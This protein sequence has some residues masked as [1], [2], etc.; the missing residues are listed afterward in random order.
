VHQTLEH[1]G[2]RAI[3]TY[4]H[5]N[6]PVH[7]DGGGAVEYRGPSA[8]FVTGVRRK[9]ADGRCACGVFCEARACSCRARLR[10]VAAT[11][12]PALAALVREHMLRVHVGSS[13]RSFWRTGGAQ[14][15]LP[16]AQ[17]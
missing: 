1:R 7:E 6:W 15:A 3:E 12:V 10:E 5:F 2:R 14:S 17:R 16:C 11:G 9:E 8:N 13:K 4:S